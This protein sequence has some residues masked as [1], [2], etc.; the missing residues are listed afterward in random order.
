MLPSLCPSFNISHGSVILQHYTGLVGKAAGMT[1]PRTMQ[2][3]ARVWLGKK[4]ESWY[5]KQ[6]LQLFSQSA[7]SF[8]SLIY[9]IAFMKNASPLSLCENVGFYAGFLANTCKLQHNSKH[10]GHV[11]YWTKLH[12]GT[13]A[14]WTI[15]KHMCTPQIVCIAHPLLPFPQLYPLNGTILNH[16]VHFEGRS[17]SAKLE[18][19]VQWVLIHSFTDVHMWL[20][21]CHVTLPGSYL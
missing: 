4:R 16:S 10:D 18:N 7:G 6:S 12:Y 19:Q 11:Q 14:E 13:S 1:W 8:F 2:V 5:G 15:L 17:E 21:S 9:T 3:V 20:G